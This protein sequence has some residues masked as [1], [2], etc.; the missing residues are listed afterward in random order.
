MTAGIRAPWIHGWALIYWCTFSPSFAESASSD[1]AAPSL[2]LF[3]PGGVSLGLPSTGAWRT[4]MA[5]CT[6]CMLPHC[7]SASGGT[8]SASDPQKQALLQVRHRFRSRCWC[9]ARSYSKLGHLS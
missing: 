8:G 6:S 9:T 3:P 4:F 7:T 2:L 1:Q 5:S